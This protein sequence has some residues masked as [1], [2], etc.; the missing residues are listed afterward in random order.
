MKI[1]YRILT[2]LIAVLLA[3]YVGYQFYTVNNAR[4]RTEM[5]LAYTAYDK[6]PAQSYFI[7]REQIIYSSADG[8]RNYN[9]TDGGKVAKGG[10]IA[11]IYLSERAASAKAQAARLE[12]EIKQ[13]EELIEQSSAQA[14]L[15]VLGGELSKSFISLLD[16]VDAGDFAG[17]QDVKS[18][19]Y[20]YMNR[21]QMVTGDPSGY[22]ARLDSLRAEKESLASQSGECLERI[23]TPSSGYFIREADGFESLVEPGDISE[24]TPERI[25]SLQAGMDLDSDRVI[26]KLVEDYE[27]HIA[28][29][30]DF[31]AASGFSRGQEYT[32]KLNA[33]TL[34][35]LPATVAEVKTYGADEDALVIFKCDQMNSELAGMRSRLI[36]I[37]KNA[38]SGIRVNSRAV[39]FM[40]DVRGVYLVKGAETRFC[41]VE[42][43]YT[44]D[45][46]VICGQAEPSENG[47]HLFDEIIVEGKDLYDGKIVR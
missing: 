20:G 18:E 29:V 1:G 7:R 5:A 15:E 41:P 46:Y 44:G 47:L 2:A 8:Y 27:W 35:E 38:F 36:D 31:A 22:S 28:C 24:L 21:R 10:V 25:L 32:L 37:V 33:A 6:V 45:G 30:T 16:R 9:L 19:I 42:V 23:V 11:E 39:R 12:E 14:D 17:I 3:A 40:D 34:D 43:L 26:G 13:T 4:I